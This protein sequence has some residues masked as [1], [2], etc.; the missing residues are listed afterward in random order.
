M[1]MAMAPSMT[2]S[3]GSRKETSVSAGPAWPDVLNP[4]LI[5]QANPNTPLAMNTPSDMDAIFPLP[6]IFLISHSLFIF[7]V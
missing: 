5:R 4:H 2:Q 6:L 3:A 7:I 1:D